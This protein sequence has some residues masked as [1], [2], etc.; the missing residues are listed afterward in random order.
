LPKLVTMLVPDGHPAAAPGGE[1][2]LVD[3]MLDRIEQVLDRAGESNL[4]AWLKGF[5][6]D[7]VRRVAPS[8]PAGEA[9]Q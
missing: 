3:T 8:L 1:A 6:D 2:R 7:Y 4:S 9:D 5:A